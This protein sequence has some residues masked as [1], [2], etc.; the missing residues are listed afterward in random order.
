MGNATLHRILRFRMGS[1]HLPVEKG[2]HFNLPWALPGRSQVAILFTLA[3]LFQRHEPA[4]LG[5]GPA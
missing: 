5:Q 2:R 4:P 3:V 1:Y